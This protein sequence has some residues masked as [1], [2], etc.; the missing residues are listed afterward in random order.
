MQCGECGLSLPIVPGKTAQSVRIVCAFCGSRYLGEVWD[1][2][3][4]N[5]KGNIRIVKD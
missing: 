4:E 2:I 5:L 3:P 1:T